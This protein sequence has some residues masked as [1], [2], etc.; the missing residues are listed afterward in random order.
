M[1]ETLE[2]YEVNMCHFSPLGGVYHLE[3]LELPPQSKPVK[4]WVLAEVGRRLL[5]SIT[6]EVRE[7][8]TTGEVG[9]SPGSITD[10]MASFLL[11]FPRS[12]H[13]THVNPILG[14]LLTHEL[15]CKPT[16]LIPQRVRQPLIPPVTIRAWKIFFSIKWPGGNHFQFGRP[17]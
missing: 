5:G 13:L 11:Q 6:G 4:G 2:P 1:P 15:V 12:Q 10:E 8:S 9:D 3:I 14:E 16:L 7:S 17:R